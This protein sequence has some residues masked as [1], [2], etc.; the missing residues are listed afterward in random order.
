MSKPVH[1]SS[2]YYYPQIFAAKALIERD[3][4]FLIFRESENASWKPGRLSLPGGKI[5][6]GE[7]W[8]TGLRRELQEEINAEVEIKGILSIEEIV[9]HNRKVDMDQLTHHIVVLAELVGEPNL[10][11]SAGWHTPEELKILDLDDLTEYYLPTV[12]ELATKPNR[13]LVPVDFVRIWKES[14]DPEF[15]AWH[16]R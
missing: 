5:D 1:F 4:K 9:Y 16:D 11:A 7:D 12:F 6:P 3:G 14:T 13:Q 15:T 2:N 10:P 8:V